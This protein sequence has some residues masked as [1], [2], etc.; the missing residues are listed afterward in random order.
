MLGRR[1][2][3]ILF[4]IL[5]YVKERVVNVHRS[6]F[7]EWKVFD[8][9]KVASVPESKYSQSGLSVCLKIWYETSTN[10][11]RNYYWIHSTLNCTIYAF[12]TSESE[13]SE[14]SST[15]KSLLKNCYIVYRSNPNCNNWNNC[16]ISIHL[17]GGPHWDTKQ[18]LFLTML[19]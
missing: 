9:L 16:K 6:H 3:L 19:G 2:S 12:Y 11:I 8:Q 14:A 18:W 1:T 7:K 13:L 4:Q 10:L 17:A 5:V 15:H